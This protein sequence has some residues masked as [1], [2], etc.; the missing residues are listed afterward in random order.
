MA[1]YIE[2]EAA[3]D[4]FQRL[5]YDDWNQG[6]CTTWANAYSE[7]AEMIDAIPAADVEPVRHGRWKMKPDPYGWFDEIPVCS[8][9]GCTTKWREKYLFCP[10][11][12]ADM[13]EVDHE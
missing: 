11:C 7:S 12:G 13:R 9:C 6:A 5:A 3:K 1:E 10:N 2:R 4:M 8:A